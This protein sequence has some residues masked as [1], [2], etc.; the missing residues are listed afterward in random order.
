M[1]H[2]TVIMTACTSSIFSPEASLRLAL[3][4]S[5]QRQ[6][7]TITALAEWVKSSGNRDGRVSQ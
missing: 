7:R 3:S 1:L 6:F 5:K 2:E 4:Y